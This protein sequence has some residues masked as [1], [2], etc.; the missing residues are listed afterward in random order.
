MLGIIRFVFFF[1]PLSPATWIERRFEGISCNRT[2]LTPF[3]SLDRFEFPTRVSAPHNPW[4]NVELNGTP[5]VS[6][7]Y[8]S[9]NYEEGP[10]NCFLRGFGG[11]EKERWGGGRNRAIIGE[12]YRCTLPFLFLPLSFFFLN[13]LRFVFHPLPPP[14]ARLKIKPISKSTNSLAATSRIT[15]LF[16]SS[17]SS[18]GKGEKNRRLSFSS[19]KDGGEEEEVGR[20]ARPEIMKSS[21]RCN[22]RRRRR[23]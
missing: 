23:L 20:N 22:S 4:K 12:L 16:F 15:F 11:K 1:F 6:A 8:H 5:S 10:S 17:P 13:P 14:L 2:R 7:V 19:C 3:P 18:C 9:I 21:K